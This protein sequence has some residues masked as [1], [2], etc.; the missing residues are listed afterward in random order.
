[1]NGAIFLARS[2]IPGFLCAV[3]ETMNL[4]EILIKFVKSQGGLTGLFNMFSAYQRSCRTTSL[5]AMFFEKMFEFCDML[6]DFDV[7]KGG[8]HS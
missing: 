5:Q 1:M 8:K 3:D 6:G 4:K 2:M 7:P